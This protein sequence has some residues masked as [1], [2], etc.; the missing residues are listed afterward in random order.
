MVHFTDQATLQQKQNARLKQRQTTSPETSSAEETMRDATATPNNGMN[1]E[2]IHDHHRP[3]PQ[4]HLV[5]AAMSTSSL[6]PPGPLTATPPVTEADVPAAETATMPHADRTAQ[7]YRPL[8]LTGSPSHTSSSPPCRATAETMPMTH[9]ESPAESYPPHIPTGS[10]THTPSIAA[11]GVAPTER[12]ALAGPGLP[13]SNTLSSSELRGPPEPAGVLQQKRSG[14]DVEGG[15][16]EDG[17][18]REVMAQTRSRKK[19]KVEMMYDCLGMPQLRH[20]STAAAAM[21]STDKETTSEIPSG[22]TVVA[23]QAQQ[24]NEAALT[25][26]A[27]NS[28]PGTPISAMQLSDQPARKTFSLLGAFVE[29]SSLI[30]ELV[31][32]LTIPALLSWYA[33]DRK[34]HW[35]YNKNCTAFMLASVRTWAPGA[36]S[37]YPWRFYQ[38][39]CLKDPTKRQKEKSGHLGPEI[40]KLNLFSRDCPSMRWLQMVVWREGVVTDMVIQLMIK[41]LRVPPGTIDA[42][43]VRQADMEIDRFLAN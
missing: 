6:G 32:Y 22:P 1:D 31:S 33:I 43:K 8:S 17:P 4:P 29:D 35:Y 21:K 41:G 18:H 39:L 16:N 9:T 10:R 11:T 20:A 5:D 24:D 38:H 23:Y 12:G 19:L 36:E 28:L 25:D 13:R 2:V 14:S 26:Q 37:I 30:I 27:G 34:F 7:L 3:H 15:H 40:F 42:V